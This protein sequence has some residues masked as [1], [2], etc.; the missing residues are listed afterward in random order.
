MLSTAS[1]AYLNQPTQHLNPALL[2]LLGG[3]ALLLAQLPL[4]GDAL[5]G[6]LPAACPSVAAVTAVDETGSAVA[7]FSNFL[8]ANGATPEDQARVIAAPGTKI[9]STISFAK[10]GLAAIVCPTCLS[11][12][13]LCL[14]TCCALL[15]A[16][17]VF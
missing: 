10:V 3:T 14:L 11:Y 17:A 2:L 6:Y 5:R 9:R 4:A 15:C 7:G 13:V 12:R 16:A 8:A 1:A